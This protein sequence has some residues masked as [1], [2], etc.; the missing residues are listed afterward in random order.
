MRQY[1]NQI[2]KK[3]LRNMMILFV[4]LGFLTTFIGQ[5]A[6]AGDEDSRTSH[7]FGIYGSVLGDPFP[8]LFGIN[9]AY[10]FTNFFRVN[11]GYGSVSASS[12][13]TTLTATSIGAGAKLFIPHWSFSPVVGFNY[14][15]VAISASGTVSGLSVNGISVS[16][17]FTNMSLG[18]DWQ[19]QMGLMLGGG[20]NFG[21]SGGLGGAP[22]F[23]LGWF[24]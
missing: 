2:V 1:S 23:N 16:G 6:R 14:T 13:T 15:N 19:T 5:S 11:L 18:F 8:S 12:G 21:L 3:S 7:R 24:F 10:N 4:G 22:F 20:Y 9:L 17:A